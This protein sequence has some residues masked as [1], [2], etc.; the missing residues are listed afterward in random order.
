MSV[1]VDAA[2]LDWENWEGADP[3]G[4]SSLHWKLLISA[5]RTG[6]SSMSMGLAEIAAG[7]V[8]P[9]HRHDPP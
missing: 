2:T 9:L 4:A 6:S 3:E 7:E 1:L 8:L 5:D